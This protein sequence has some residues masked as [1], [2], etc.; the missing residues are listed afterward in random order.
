MYVYIY[1]YMRLGVLPDLW[2]KHDQRPVVAGSRTN[3]FDH[4]E[5]THPRFEGPLLEQTQ[6]LED[7]PPAAVCSSGRSSGVAD[8]T[9]GE[10]HGHLYQ[11]F[12]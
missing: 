3:A 12:F 4:V 2:T 1:I 5:S 11:T 8:E 10:T 6:S 7:R 9:H